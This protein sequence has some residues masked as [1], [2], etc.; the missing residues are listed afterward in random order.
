MGAT[1]EALDAVLGA[2][3]RA[4]TAGD[5]VQL[6]GFGSF[7]AGQRAARTGRNPSTGAEIRIVAART[8]MFTPG[9]AFKEAVNAGW[10][11]ACG[12]RYT[13]RLKKRGPAVIMET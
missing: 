6:V 13:C 11:P 4:L 9:K 5:A 2:I 7:P 8:V 10:R 1:G 3:R 12:G